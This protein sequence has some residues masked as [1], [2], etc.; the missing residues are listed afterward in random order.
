MNAAARGHCAKR[1][2]FGQRVRTSPPGLLRRAPP[3][4]LGERYEDGIGLLLYGIPIKKLPICS[5][6]H[7]AGVALPCHSKRK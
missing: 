1:G 7:T 4:M 6:N 2:D 3:T 5:R